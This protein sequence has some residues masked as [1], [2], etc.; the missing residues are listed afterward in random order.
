MPAS[1]S[2]SL[3]LVIPF[4]PSSF[5]LAVAHTP[6]LSLSLSLSLVAGIEQTAESR[7]QRQWMEQMLQVETDNIVKQSM[8]ETES[9]TPSPTSQCWQWCARDPCCED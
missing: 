4:S 9:I 6:Y 8:E 7:L 5:P 2:L 3:S 1:L